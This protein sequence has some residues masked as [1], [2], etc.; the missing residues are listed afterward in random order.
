MYIYIYTHVYLSCSLYKRGSEASHL[1]VDDLALEDV[2]QPHLLLEAGQ[3]FRL[4]GVQSLA[5]RVY[6]GTSPIRNRVPEGPY[7]RTMPRALW[8]PRG[9][10]SAS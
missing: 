4:H 10:I 8:K 1:E 6:R 9:Y 5:S 2:D 3:Q 7:S